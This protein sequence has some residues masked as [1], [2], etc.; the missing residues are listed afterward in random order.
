[1]QPGHYNKTPPP[2]VHLSIK[3][4]LKLQISIWRL[5][6]SRHCI[7]LYMLEQ[8]SN[9][10]QAADQ[11]QNGCIHLSYILKQTEAMFPMNNFKYH[12]TMNI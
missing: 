7:L 1:M 8:V 6:V 2:Q 10:V 12:Q 4:R 11:K 5:S 3:L 9:K